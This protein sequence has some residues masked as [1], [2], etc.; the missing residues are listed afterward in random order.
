MILS[1]HSA[2]SWSEPKQIRIPLCHIAALSGTTSVHCSGPPAALPLPLPTTV[3]IDVVQV[4]VRLEVPTDMADVEVETW[5]IVSAANG[6]E[7]RITNASLSVLVCRVCLH[8]TNE[9]CIVESGG[10]EWSTQA[11]IVALAWPMSIGIHVH[12]HVL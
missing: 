8:L 4:V 7:S 10:V 1:V 11:M 12:V 2:T 5:C 9:D 6:R 3:Y